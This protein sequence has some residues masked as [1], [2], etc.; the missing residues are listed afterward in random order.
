MLRASWGTNN[1]Q[2]GVYQPK[3]I[4]Q[5][6]D[7]ARGF[8][9]LEV[10]LFH[11]VLVK[12]LSVRTRTLCEQSFDTLWIKYKLQSIKKNEPSLKDSL[13][14]SIK[15]GGHPSNLKTPSYNPQSRYRLYTGT[16]SPEDLYIFSKMPGISRMEKLSQIEAKRFLK[17]E[18][19]RN[20]KL[21]NLF[22]EHH[23]PCSYYQCWYSI[24]LLD[25]LHKELPNIVPESFNAKV[26]TSPVISAEQLSEI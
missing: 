2:G 1:L 20:H 7:S 14:G 11:P 4:L 15:I 10:F 22:K 23:N 25:L 26:R 5:S 16:S 9:Q 13:P 3:W 19:S 21:I 24:L 12:K 18:L 8:F 17:L 6:K